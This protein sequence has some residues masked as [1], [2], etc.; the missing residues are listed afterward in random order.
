M[1]AV[2][3]HG[4]DIITSDFHEMSDE[5][6]SKAVVRPAIRLPIIELSQA[7][8]SEAGPSYGVIE[9]RHF[10]ASEYEGAATKGRV[11]A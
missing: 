9:R 10:R 2:F 6:V 5:G 3:H 7:G 8:S 11:S 1:V 4:A